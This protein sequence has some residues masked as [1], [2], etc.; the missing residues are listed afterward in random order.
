M[1]RIVI[2]GGPGSGKTTIVDELKRQSF[3]CFEEVSRDIISNMNI[4]TVHKDIPF[5]EHIFNIR[6]Q[7]FHKAHNDLQFYDRSMLDTL[8]Y[9]QANNHAIP[10]YMISDC[11][12]HRYFSS[13]FILPPWNDIYTVDRERLESFEEAKTIYH[14]LTQVYS[15]FNYSLIE[16]PKLSPLL[17]TKF[18]LS[19]I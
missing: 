16:V 8:A 6:K 13:V 9:M 19:K 11:E 5:E 7:D 10:K 12:D 2:T 15:Q 18:I 3:I 17:R 4:T 1:K 14:E